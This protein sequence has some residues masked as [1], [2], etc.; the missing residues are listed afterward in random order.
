MASSSK[1]LDLVRYV[2]QTLSVKRRNG[3]IVCLR[4]SASTSNPLYPF[5]D[6]SGGFYTPEGCTFFGQKSP[7]DIVK[8]LGI[9]K[10]GM[11]RSELRDFISQTEDYARQL[12][13][14]L[15]RRESCPTL[16][17]ASEGDVLEDDPIVLIKCANTAILVSPSYTETKATWSDTF[18]ELN[19]SLKE[20]GFNP[21]EWFVPNKSLL[22]LA[23]TNHRRSFGDCWYWSSSEID[24]TR[25]EA[26]DFRDEGSYDIHLKSYKGCVRAFRSVYF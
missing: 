6:S 18:L 11:G 13:L 7:D 14:E 1:V 15:S 4:I 9:R 24:D 5:Q 22:H 26:V 23:M 2:G 10:L 21:S 17:E 16:Q 12:K 3:S 8:I 25:A 19:D 20:G